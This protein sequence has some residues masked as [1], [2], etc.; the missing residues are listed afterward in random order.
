MKCQDIIHRFPSNVSYT[1]RSVGLR[2]VEVS[3]GKLL[4]LGEDWEPIP[5]IGSLEDVPNAPSQLRKHIAQ[6]TSSADRS[7][8][9][10][11]WLTC[12]GDDPE[13]MGKVNYFPRQ[14]FPIY[15]YPLV[16]DLPSPFVFVQFENPKSE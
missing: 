5:Y 11:V 16:A 2:F 4:K 8:N 7:V 3:K 6:L 13:V 12:E 15:Y 10:M 1:L 14:G 9:R